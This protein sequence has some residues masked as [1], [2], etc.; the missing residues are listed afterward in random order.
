MEHLHTIDPYVN[1]MVEVGP[2]NVVKVE[3]IDSFGGQ[4]QSE[5]DCRDD[6]DALPNSVNGSISVAEA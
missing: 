3:T 6:A 5:D 1:T 4:I 2:G